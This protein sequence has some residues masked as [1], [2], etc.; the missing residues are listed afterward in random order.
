MICLSQLLWPSG[1]GGYP[2]IVIWHFGR[3]GYPMYPLDSL[4]YRL[5]TVVMFMCPETVNVYHH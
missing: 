3:G 5:L 4:P 2:M 1:R